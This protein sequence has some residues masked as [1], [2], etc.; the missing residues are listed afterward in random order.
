MYLEFKTQLYRVESGLSFYPELTM[1]PNDM[2]EDPS[3]LS[4]LPEATK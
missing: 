3:Q 2:L 1:L 4:K